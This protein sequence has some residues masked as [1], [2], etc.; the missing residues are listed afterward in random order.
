MITSIIIEDEV[1]SRKLLNSMINNYCEG[2]EVIGEAGDVKGGVRL[3]RE[4]NPDIVFLDIE[5]GGGT[6]FD[7]L[8]Q[9][10]EISLSII[11]ISGYDKYALKAI[12]HAALDY[13]LKPI[14][15]KELRL[16]IQKVYDNLES[17]SDKNSQK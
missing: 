4:K 11:I 2:I 12:K 16:A 10:N 17:T 6:G 13:I 8:N 7:I 1:R 15:L 14:D 9:V 3:I 5:I